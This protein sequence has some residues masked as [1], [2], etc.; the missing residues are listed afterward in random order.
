MGTTMPQIRLTPLDRLIGFVSPRH[1]VRRVRDR[2][3]WGSLSNT[4]YVGFGSGRRSMRG[5]QAAI[6][7]AD[8]DTAP[9]LD[10]LRASTRD[11]DM[12]SPVAT[13]VHSRLRTSVIGY[14]LSM[15]CQIDRNFLGL[16]DKDAEEWQQHTQREFRMWADSRECDATRTQNFYELQ[17]LALIS[18]IMSGDVFA[19]LPYI[20]RKGV[21]YDLRVQLIEADLVCNP[22]RTYDTDTLA[23]GIEVDVNGAPVRYHVMSSHP[24]SF[25]PVWKW[26]QISAY[27]EKSGRRNMLHLYDRRRPGQRRG[28]P[29]LAPVIETLKQITRL[30][31]AELMAAVVTSF[32]TAFIK[33]ESGSD[34]L[35]TGFANDGTSEPSLVDGS[36][37]AGDDRM[38]EMG[39]GTIM[40]LDKNESVELAD[41]KRPNSAFEPFFNAMVK[42][43]GAATEIPYELILLNF[44]ASYSASR[45]ALL[46]AWKMFKMRRARMVWQFCQPVYEA[47]LV[48][49]VSRG[50]VKAPGFFEDPAVRTAWSG[51][52]WNGPGQGQLSPV[53]ETEAALKRIAGNLSTHN[54]ETAALDGDDWETMVATRGQEQRTLRGLGLV[55]DLPAPGPV[56]PGESGNGAGDRPSDG[57]D[58][59]PTDPEEMDPEE[60]DLEDMTNPN[61]PPVEDETDEGQGE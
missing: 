22:G 58:T 20:Q 35:D 52:S 12:N 61:K 36:Q 21:P 6:Q 33:T 11:M 38:Y 13:A 8:R 26:N 45:G 55:Q 15:Q 10:I 53:Q 2:A 59:T 28:V 54:K 60:M 16:T 47:W 23:G 3:M 31:E 46:E 43:I 1:G 42:L 56:A 17:G 4:G 39:S 9:K 49:A 44:T 51:A 57:E 18:E 37:R 25:L 50:R 41:P 14:G 29:L 32:F 30:T 40:S 34:P 24:G 48:E 7:S 27:G 19:A 5:A